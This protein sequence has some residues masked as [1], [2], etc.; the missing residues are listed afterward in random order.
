MILDTIIYVGASDSPDFCEAN[1]N[2]QAFVYVWGEPSILPIYPEN[3]VISSCEF[4]EIR[5]IYNDI[6]ELNHS[7][8]V[9]AINEDVFDYSSEEINIY[10]DTIIFIPQVPFRDSSFIVASVIEAQNI[11]GIDWDGEA[12]ISF[13]IDLQPPIAL[14]TDPNSL[15]VPNRVP[16]LSLT[17]TDNLA[18]IESD[19]I[20]L[21]VNDEQVSFTVSGDDFQQIIDFVPSNPY[22]SGDTV[23]VSLVSCDMAE[24]CGGNCSVMDTFFIISPETACESWPNPFT[25]ND[26]GYGDYILFSYPDQYFSDAELI[27]FDTR[28]VEV[29]RKEI[30]YEEG[31][32]LWDGFD[33]GGQKAA[34]GLYI[35]LIAKD[36]GKLCEGTIVLIR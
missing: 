23:Y 2:E 32:F 15:I 13:F 11:Y 8:I 22:P 20:I 31:R 14:L 7:S 18:G 1:A 3:G 5:F 35:Y 34:N 29:F 9:V 12:Q 30:G 24:L 21:F 19:S 26:D 4:Q 6:V 25:P 27:I 17:L 33:S 16:D 36:N 10:G 28:S